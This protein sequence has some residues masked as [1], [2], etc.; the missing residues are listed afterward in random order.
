MVEIGIDYR[1]LLC[2]ALSTA[3]L[4]HPRTT[5]FARPAGER[6]EERRAE[7]GSKK[8]ETSGDPQKLGPLS[9]VSR[10]SSSMF[11]QPD[12]VRVHVEQ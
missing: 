11:V 1:A 10:H 4:C 5:E 6:R 12:T 3:V 7:E 8:K 9:I 2:A